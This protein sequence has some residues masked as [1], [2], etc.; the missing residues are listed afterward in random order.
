[1]VAKPEVVLEWANGEYLFALRLEQIEALES[2]CRNPHTGK[3]GVGIAAIW[4][5]LTS[6]TWYVSDITNT[7]RL[8]LIGGGM[9]AVEAMRLVNNYVS[10]V[11]LSSIKNDRGP[12]SPL[13]VAQAILAS[14]MVGVVGDDPGKEQETPKS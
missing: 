5:R 8:G 3:N 11:P 13:V 10:T 1:M 6:G 9:G 12:N 4:M 2:E 14:A 7:I